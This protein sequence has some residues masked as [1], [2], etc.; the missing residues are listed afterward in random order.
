MLLKLQNNTCSETSVKSKPLILFFPVSL[1][2]ERTVVRKRAV[3]VLCSAF[4]RRTVTRRCAAQ[5]VDAA[6]PLACHFIKFV[7]G[8][9]MLFEVTDWRVFGPSQSPSCLPLILLLRHTG[10]KN[11]F[12]LSRRQRNDGYQPLINE[13]LLPVKTPGFITPRLKAAVTAVKILGNVT[14]D[15]EERRWLG[16]KIVWHLWWFVLGFRSQSLTW[17]SASF[18]SVEDTVS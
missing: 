10:T 12:S 14:S 8:V 15:G 2:M 11:A 18:F 6:R 9:L 4:M 3:L 7:T 1:E 13:T 16:N 17:K 5:Y